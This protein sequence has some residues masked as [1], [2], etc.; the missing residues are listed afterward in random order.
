MVGASE[1]M[2]SKILITGKL[3][4]KAI[5][6]FK[7][8]DQLEVTYMPDRTFD[9]FKGELAKAHVL[10]TRSET[11]VDRH[12]IDHASELKVIARAAVGVGNIDLDYATER[13][14]LVMNTPGKNTNS[15][16]EL[17]LGLI[18]SMLR[19]IPEAQNHMK[20]GGWDRHLFT[21]IELRNKKVGLVGLGNVGKRVAQF[22]Q[23][24]DA[25]VFAY[26][27]YISPQVF[28]RHHTTSVKSLEELASLVDILSVH[29]P[30]NKETTGMITHNVLK[31]LGPEGY[32]INAARGGI[33]REDDL[34]K[35][36]DDKLIAGVAL[37]TFDNEPHP[38]P[39]LVKHDKVWVTPHIGASTEEAQ[40]AIG[41]SVYQQVCKAVSGG[42]VDYHVNLP[43]VGVIDKPVLKSYSTLAEKLGSIA[44]QILDFNP[45]QVRLQYRG[46]IADLD[47]SI[48]RLS[49][50]KGYADQV[51]D[52]YV[53]FV[54]VNKHFSRLGIDV[55][56]S[57]DPSF[58]S[59]KSALKVTITG[60]QGESLSIGGVVFED[61]HLR[62]TLLND[63][64]FEV[65]PTGYLLLIKN[66]D[67][68][69]VIGDVGQ[70][71]ATH[72]VNIS[73]FSLS[74][75]ARGGL[76]MAILSV[77]E[78]LNQ[79][80]LAELKTLKNIESARAITL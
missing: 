9:E 28:T 55:T 4:P 6:Q 38:N 41:A 37:D 40:L 16:A 66:I 33:A 11:T 18:L 57:K 44:G 46:D 69:G 75:S 58:S 78:Q 31:L 14:I 60:K 70:F 48:I 35:A 10:I 7:G 26:D 21:G 49:W 79:Q 51:V 32:F 25:E 73:S 71:L 13:G 54:N 24:F 27:P 22:C 39:E 12:L 72:N 42:V 3:H 53:S 77:D 74:R 61:R 59:Y 23:G 30:K 80:Q 67:K 56:E 68:P 15:A 62:L 52:D 47:N 2:K 45:N 1:N 29:V 8:N 50:M 36:L 63:F 5:E 34:L 64:V 43:E 65:E 76:A 20:S 17:T 19:H